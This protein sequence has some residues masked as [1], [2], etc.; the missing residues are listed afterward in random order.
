[1]AEAAAAPKTPTKA[2]PKRKAPAKRKPAAKRKTPAKRKPIA[3]A[4]TKIEKSFAKLE[5]TSSELV[6]KA[7]ETSRS[8]FLA[9][10]GCYGMAFDKMSDQ[11]DTVQAKFDSRKKEAD[12]VYKKLVKRG[13]KL[14]KDAMKAMDDFHFSSFDFE[15]LT[16]RSK[17]EAS[18]GKAKAAFEELK[19]SATSRFAM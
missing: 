12:K 11:V 10:L 17:L 8:A 14:E 9:G 18:L 4:E 13:E 15:E 5:K 2:A 1:M 7:K 19:S 3:K 16:D 6:S